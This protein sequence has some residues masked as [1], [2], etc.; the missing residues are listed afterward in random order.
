MVT[1]WAP[2]RTT[3]PVFLPIHVEPLRSATGTLEQRVEYIWNMLT[4][5]LRLVT[6]ALRAPV[7]GQRGKPGIAEH[8]DRREVRNLGAQRAY[9]ARRT[10]RVSS[11]HTPSP[12]LAIASRHAVQRRAGT[13]SP[14]SGTPLPNPAFCP[15]PVAVTRIDASKRRETMGRPRN[16]STAAP[17]QVP[18]SNLT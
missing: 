8:T 2:K 10:S 9:P 11:R 16:A 17:P 7:G 14:G 3:A 6:H 5:Y 18:C 4:S 1:S 15:G 13:Q 12:V